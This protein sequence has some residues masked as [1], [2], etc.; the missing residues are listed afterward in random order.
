MKTANKAAKQTETKNQAWNCKH[1]H[2]TNVY[3]SVCGCAASLRDAGRDADPTAGKGMCE[4]W[5]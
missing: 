3:Q 1:C 4:L 2:A 5:F